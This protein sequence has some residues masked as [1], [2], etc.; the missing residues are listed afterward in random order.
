MENQNNKQSKIW[1]N[2][3]KSK[4]VIA[5]IL[6]FIT[7]IL[8]WQGPINKLRKVELDEFLA[9]ELIEDYEDAYHYAL[10]TILYSNYYKETD[11]EKKNE[12][13]EESMSKFKK[14]LSDK[15]YKEVEKSI[16]VDN[17]YDDIDKFE[18]E[19]DY[20]Y[21]YKEGKNKKYSLIVDDENDTIELVKPHYYKI[22]RKTKD[23]SKPIPSDERKYKV[24]KKLF[25]INKYILCGRI[26]T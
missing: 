10:K 7:I 9:K 4:K 26:D 17:E 3:S 8:G 1:E 21:T 23:R 18:Y 15:L 13:K 16:F 25:T 22:D 20:T 6:G 24:K 5:A 19:F 11:T 12:I 2:M 14:I